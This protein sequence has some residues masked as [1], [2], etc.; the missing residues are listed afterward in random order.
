ME[1]PAAWGK[2]ERLINE[3][4]REHTRA[5]H[6]GRVGLSLAM[7]VANKLREAGLLKDEDDD[8]DD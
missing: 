2:A 7:K 3:V 4:H 5:M 8:D 1:N 6:E